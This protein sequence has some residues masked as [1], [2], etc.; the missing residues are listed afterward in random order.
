MLI[1]TQVDVVVED[2]VEVEIGKSS[3]NKTFLI[4]IENS[5]RSK[6]DD[7]NR[8]TGIATMYTVYLYPLPLCIK[9]LQ[10]TS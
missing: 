5:L 3:S 8:N 10:T 1:S 6:C 7:S 4:P 2:E 9:C